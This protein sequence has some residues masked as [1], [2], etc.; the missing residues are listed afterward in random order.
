M[1]APEVF[2]AEADLADVEADPISAYN[3]RWQSDHRESPPRAGLE[4]SRVRS[5]R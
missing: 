2:L 3:L 5:I 4:V 1:E